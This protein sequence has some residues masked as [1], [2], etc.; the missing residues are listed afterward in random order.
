MLTVPGDIPLVTPAEITQLLAAHRPA[1]AFT[2]APSRDERGSNAIICSPPDAVPLRFGEDSFF[3]HLRAAE[4]CGIRPTV[5]RLPGIALDVDTPEDLAALTL[6]PSATRAHALLDLQARRGSYGRPLGMT[7]DEIV[8]RVEAGRRL[9]AAEALALA[10][11]SDLQSLMRVAAALRDKAHG[12]LVS[13]SRKVFIP[14]TQLCR[15]VCHYCTFAHPPRAGEP[16]YLSAERGAGDRPR[17]RRAPA[18][19]R[20]CSRLGDKPELRYG[21][22]REALAQL[23]HE[24][25]L[26]YLAEMA[27]L[28]LRE[29]GL[30][31]HLNPGVMTARRHRPAAR[32][33]GLAGH[34]A[35]ERVGA[36]APPR[37]AAFR[38]AGQGPGAA[39]RNH[40]RRRR[41][42]GAVHLRHPDRHRRDPARADR[43]AAGAARPARRATATCR[44]SSSRIS[45]PSRARAWRN[46][47]EPDLD[48]HLWTIAVARLIFGPEMNIQAPPNLNPGALAADDRRRHQRLGRRLAGHARSRQSR[49]G[50]GRHSTGWREQTAAAGKV[51]VERLA[52]Y[53]AYARD[54]GALARPGAAR[55]PCCARSMP[56][57]CARRRLGARRRRSSR[58]PSTPRS[59][60]LRRAAAIAAAVTAS[61][62][63]IARAAHRR[64]RRSSEAEIV[65]LFAARGDEFDAV[66][67]G[68]RRA[69]AAGQRRHGQLR[70]HPQHQLH[71]HLLF[72]L[73]VLRVL[74]GQAQ[75]KPARPAL[76]PRPRRRSSGAVEEAWERGATEVCM[77]GGIHP[78][79]TGATYLGDL[80]GD[81]GGGARHAHPRLLAARDLARRHDPRPHAS[82]ISCAS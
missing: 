64:A 79:Y 1:P 3:P 47:P 78:E 4:A 40:P 82:P 29:T 46:A 36:A 18:A 68:R 48:E 23:G 27:A 61:S 52:I 75:R 8:S 73:P 62:H 22:A 53:P 41:G 81:Q 5:L 66:C 39:A 77:Q 35:G 63:A 49:G 38:L 17:R 72:P 11:H 54:A 42:G 26:S 57:A 51:L 24:T 37:R 31:P 69:A 45:G 65:R 10:D 44:R 16:A 30:L 13:Y 33:V 74:E 21:A 34:H 14:L 19:T 67:R 50:R 15:D 80:P 70:R 25:T 2:I 6:V 56:R 43:G 12:D 76:R 7:T 60:R 9:S 20:R 28:V 55:R 32:G 59:S 71:Q 58:R